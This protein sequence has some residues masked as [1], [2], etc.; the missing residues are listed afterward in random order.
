MKKTLTFIAAFLFLALN[1]QEKRIDFSKELKYSFVGGKEKTTDISFKSLGNTSGEFL[2]QASFNMFPINMFSD[3]LGMSTVNIGLN[4]KLSNSSTAMM[5]FGHGSAFS[6][7][8]TYDA[9]IKQ[10]NTNETILGLSCS[11][12]LI[13][14]PISYDEQK[15]KKQ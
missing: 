3:N 1:A 12:Y 15:T 11:H 5:M 14:Y 9:E 10:L 4:N 7:G 6:D 13:T 8:K 2:T